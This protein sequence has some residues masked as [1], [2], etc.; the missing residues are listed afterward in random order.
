MYKEEDRQRPLIVVDVD[1]VLLPYQPAGP[2]KNRGGKMRR[3]GWVQAPKM[4]R[5]MMINPAHGAM[6]KRLAADTGAELV[7]GS[8]WEDS[9]NKVIAPLV[10]LPD[11]MPVLPVRKTMVQ[12]GSKAVG[13]LIEM[14]GRPFVWFD[15]DEYVGRDADDYAKQPHLVIRTND[16]EGLTPAQ[17]ARA[18]DWLLDIRADQD[19][20]ALWDWPVVERKAA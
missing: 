1:G 8:A 19:E 6:L 18:R 5:G 3:A 9:A 14:H 13:A 10:G 12:Y 7:W 11:N 17:I 20:L 4:A 2:L 16:E 15:D